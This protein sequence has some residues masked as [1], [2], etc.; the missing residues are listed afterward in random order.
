MWVQSVQSGATL[1][2]KTILSILNIWS[3]QFLHVHKIEANRAI[4]SC[5]FIFSCVRTNVNTRVLLFVVLYRVSRWENIS[6]SVVFLFPW[7]KYFLRYFYQNL[8]R[9][10]LFVLS[11]YCFCD[12]KSYEFLLFF[13]ALEKLK[14]RKKT[15][16]NFRLLFVF[17]LNFLFHVMAVVW[18][19]VDGY[20]RLKTT[21]TSS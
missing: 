12:E 4:V 3:I 10:I 17:P 21:L 2:S 13:S 19:T 16:V 18:Y 5:P 15:W 1:N 7:M 6:R 11:Q 14:Y 9:I 8:T 20:N